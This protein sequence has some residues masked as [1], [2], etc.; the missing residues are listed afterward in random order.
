MVGDE[1]GGELEAGELWV[2]DE[3]VA[4]EADY[5]AGF[6]EC[7]DFDAFVSY[8]GVEGEDGGRGDG[9]VGELC[10][11]VV[12]DGRKVVIFWVD[13]RVLVDYLVIF[14]GWWGRFGGW[15]RGCVC[16]WGKPCGVSGTPGGVE[17]M[18]TSGVQREV[19]TPSAFWE[20]ALR[21]GDAAGGC[22]YMGECE[23]G[24]GGLVVGELLVLGHEEGDDLVFG[25]GGRE[26]VGLEDGEVVLVVCLAEVVWH[27]EG[28]VECGEAFAGVRGAGVED[29]LCGAGDALCGGGVGVGPGEVVVD[30]VFGV[31]VVA[32]EAAAY[33]AH[34]GVVEGAGED[35]EVVECGVG[36]DEDKV[37][38]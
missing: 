1:A 8:A 4:F 38:T 35:A 13:N 22:L 10:E 34:P 19:G 9:D 14:W 32:F 26:V 33:G 31:A 11:D 20:N 7:G 6:L 37:R 25:G 21:R 23:W 24:C 2:Y 18:W 12:H 16:E 36:D 17:G 30:D 15:G 5:V 28:V 29:G 27:E 3:D